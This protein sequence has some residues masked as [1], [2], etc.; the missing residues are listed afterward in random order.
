MTNPNNPSSA[1]TIRY[2]LLSYS[3]QKGDE[4]I[5]AARRDCKA[6]PTCDFNIW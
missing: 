1:S 2:P 5:P 4:D 3:E 6:P